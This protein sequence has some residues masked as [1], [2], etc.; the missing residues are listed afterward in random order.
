V[1][2]P[3]VLLL[4]YSRFGDDVTLR[5]VNYLQAMEEEEEVSVHCHAC[6]SRQ[7]V[8]LL[9]LQLRAQLLYAELHSP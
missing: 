9:F 6:K 7:R 2:P 5:G 1:Q 8:T 4:K 3:F